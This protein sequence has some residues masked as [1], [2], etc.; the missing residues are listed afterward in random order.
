MIPMRDGV[1]LYTVIYRPRRQSED[2]PFLLFRTPYG[3]YS[4]PASGRIGLGPSRHSFEF[5]NE[6]FIFVE[7]DVRGQNKS[8]GEFTVMRPFRPGKTGNQTDESSDTYDT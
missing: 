8:E 6:G 1:K 4:G 7:Q 5:E 2:L 3:I